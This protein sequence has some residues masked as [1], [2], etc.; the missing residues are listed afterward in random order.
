MT[1]LCKE[2]QVFKN[3]KNIFF[4][5]GFLARVGTAWYNRAVLINFDKKSEKRIVSGTSGHQHKPG[6]KNR[7]EHLFYF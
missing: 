7:D 3:R 1:F 2:S 5:S 4:L 6:Q